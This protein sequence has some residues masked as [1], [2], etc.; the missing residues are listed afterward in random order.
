MKKLLTILIIAAFASS[1]EGPMGPMGPEGKINKVYNLDLEIKA[2]Q[3]KTGT[4]IIGP[5]YYGD[6][7]IPELDEYMIYD[8]DGLYQLTWRYMEDGFEIRQTLE[9]TIYHKDSG[10]G[11]QWSENISVQFS[12]GEARVIIRYS[13]FDMSRTPPAMQFMFAGMY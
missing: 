12:V 10:T 4:D 1:C 3:W 6:L 2:N 9:T 11:Y 7:T 8:G 5:H 13:D